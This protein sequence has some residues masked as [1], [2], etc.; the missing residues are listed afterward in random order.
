VEELASEM[1]NVIRANQRHAYSIRR[2][3]N[4]TKEIK[5]LGTTL[6]NRGHTMEKLSTKRQ[7]CFAQKKRE[8]KRKEEKWGIA[9]SIS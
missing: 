4:I 7:P 6:S 9:K 8:R 1:S 5:H 3:G 2:K